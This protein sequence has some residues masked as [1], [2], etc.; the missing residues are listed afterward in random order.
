MLLFPGITVATTAVAPWGKETDGG[1]L[2][3]PD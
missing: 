2:A 3:A 1:I